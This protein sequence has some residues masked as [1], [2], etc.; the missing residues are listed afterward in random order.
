MRSPYSMFFR[1]A[2]AGVLSLVLSACGGGGG[3]SAATQPGGPLP[4]PA[5][6]GPGLS[7]LQLIDDNF[8]F[9]AAMVD[10]N[11]PDTI[12]PLTEATTEFRGRVA[13]RGSVYF[14]ILRPAGVS[15]DG[16]YAVDTASPGATVRLSQQGHDVDDP[17]ISDDGNWLAYGHGGDIYVVN[18]A[19]PGSATRVNDTLASGVADRFV[20]GP[21]NDRILYSAAQDTPSVRELYT[22]VLSQLSSTTKLNAPLTA[23]DDVTDFAISPDGATVAYQADHDDDGGDDVYTVSVST[24][25]VATRLSGAYGSGTYVARGPWFSD[26]GDQVYYTA[27]VVDS[28]P[29]PV[30]L[31]VASLSNPGT[32]QALNAPFADINRNV[33]TILGQIPGTPLLLYTSDEGTDEVTELFFTN[34]ALPGTTVRVNGPL[35]PGGAVDRGVPNLQGDKILYTA[36]GE[37]AGQLDLYLVELATP[38][39]AVKVSPTMQA[40]SPGVISLPSFSADGE[41]FY[42]SLT[43]GRL[44][45]TVPFV[46]PVATP[47]SGHV[48]T[49]NL[50]NE[51]ALFHSS[52]NLGPVAP[53]L[54]LD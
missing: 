50:T 42:Y 11:D 29:A 36:E 12:I 7:Y 33:Q 1:L 35:A 45:E 39:T 3:G 27:Q 22:V 44:D 32:D 10:P 15:E 48:Q 9:R 17:I 52:I 21:L 54:G 37:A 30:G 49:A 18:L 43:E 19:N 14:F 34:L 5:D 53:T 26:A 41:Y 24:P 38:G 4:P 16:V 23:T 51:G 20:F 40:G 8:E 47:E 6:T 13:T 46:A 2:S 31:R 28:F 25:G